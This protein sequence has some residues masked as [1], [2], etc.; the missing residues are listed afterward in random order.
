[1]SVFQLRGGTYG[2][3]LSDPLKTSYAA[4]FS[5]LS[6]KGY[7]FDFALRTYRFA[8]ARV[9]NYFLSLILPFPK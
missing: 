9:Y 6:P 4:G 7:Q 8:D 3:S 2:E 5:A 1:M